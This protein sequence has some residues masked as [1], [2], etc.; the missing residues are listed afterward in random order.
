MGRRAKPLNGRIAPGYMIRKLREKNGYT[1]E[2]LA[3]KAGVSNGSISR[4]EA[5]LQQYSGEFLN[6]IANAFNVDVSY[7]FA[8]DDETALFMKAAP[9]DKEK[10]AKYLSAIESIKPPPLK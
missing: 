2:V 9:E 7:L 10:C 3:K 1:Q 8:M 5:G 4:I 6:K